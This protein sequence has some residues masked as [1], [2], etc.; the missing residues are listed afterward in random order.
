[1]NTSG[2]AQTTM[3][4]RSGWLFFMHLATA[5]AATCLPK[6]P[7]MW[8]IENL[9]FSDIILFFNKNRRYQIKVKY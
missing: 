6:P 4:S 3:S 8:K 2:Y 1:M 9:L 7:S 5:V